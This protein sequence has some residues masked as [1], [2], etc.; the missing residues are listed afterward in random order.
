MYGSFGCVV[1]ATGKVDFLTTQAPIDY[2]TGTEPPEEFPSVVYT[3]EERSY[4]PYPFER[5]GIKVELSNISK[6]TKITLPET[7]TDLIRTMLASGTDFR[8]SRCVLR[9][10]FP[11][12]VEEGSDIILLDGY[13]QDWSYSPDKKGILFTISKTLIDVGSSFPKRLMN[14]GC[15]HVFK[16]DRCQYFGADGICTKTKT[17]CTAKGA[18]ARFGGFPWVAAR[19]RRVMWR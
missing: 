8:G 9:R 2:G 1:T 19:Q 3:Y 7:Q 14:M 15:S 10:M 18:V 16:G 5:E 12:H 11:D 17:D 13:I 4:I 6:T